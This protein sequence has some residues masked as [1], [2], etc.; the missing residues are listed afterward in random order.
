MSSLWPLLRGRVYAARLSNLDEDKYFLVVSNNR[1]NNQL[2]QV[3][4][5]RL[6]TTPKPDLP[7]IV[8]LG[9]PEAFNGSVICD[10]IVEI[11]QDEVTRDL[12]ALSPRAMEAV[13]RGLMA[14]LDL[15]P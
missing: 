12:G 6:T 14:A 7:S 5:V 1:R 4:A 8:P 10:D 9:P 13:G 3:L 15:S 2:P 11:W